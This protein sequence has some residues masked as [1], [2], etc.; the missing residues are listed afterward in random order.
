MSNISYHAG[1]L[2]KVNLHKNIAEIQKEITKLEYEVKDFM[3]DNYVEF[4][5][6]LTRDIHLV[7]KTE[8]LLEEIGIL[9]SRINDQVR[10]TSI[11]ITLNVIKH[12]FSNVIYIY[13]TDQ[14]RIVWIDQRVEGTFPGIKGVQYQPATI[15]S[16]D[17]PTQVYKIYKNDTRGKTVR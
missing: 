16:T 17:K 15:P 2:E 10:C 8:Q 4:N 11:S 5:A 7:K 14:N 1:K 9:Q 12:M 3:D 13:Y 6:K